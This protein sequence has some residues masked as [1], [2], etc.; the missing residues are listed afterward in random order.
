MPFALSFKTPRISNAEKVKEEP[1]GEKGAG[2]PPPTHVTVSLTW[3]FMHACMCMLQH[4]DVCAYLTSSCTIVTI[5]TTHDICLYVFSMGG[6]TYMLYIIQKISYFWQID[7]LTTL[8][9]EGETNSDT[10]PKLIDLT[11]T[12]YCTGTKT[13]IW[14][15]HEKTT[16]LKKLE[17]NKFH[18][19]LSVSL[20]AWKI[21][22]NFDILVYDYITHM[23]IIFSF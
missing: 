5:S 1:G 6:H 19:L 17:H 8:I 13:A 16:N 23:S 11:N 9:Q 10:L 21:A 2:P 18:L 7:I 22:W 4:H 20:V 14:E 12:L 3:S 15:H